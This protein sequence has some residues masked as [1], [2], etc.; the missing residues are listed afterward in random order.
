MYV[1][2]PWSDFEPQQYRF[3]DYAAYFRKVKRAL[4]TA[5]AA[6]ATDD[7]YPDPIEHC[8]I[9]RWREAC[10]KRRR[11]DDHLCLVAGISK[12]QINELKARD[13]ATVQGLAGM[14][15]PLEW[16][17]DRGSADSYIRIREQARIVVEARETGD[18][19][20]ELLPVETGFGLTRLPE[21]SE[22]DVFL[23]LEGDPF[24]GE[25]GLEYLFGYL[26][27]DAHGAL[28]YEGDWAFT[29]ADEKRAFEKF[30]DFVMARWALFPGLHV[31]HYAPYEPAALKRLM[32]RYATREEEIDRMLRAGLFVDLYQVVRHGLRASVESYSIKRLEPFYGF[33]RQTP[34]DRCKCRACQSPGESRARAMRRRLPRRPRQR[35]APTTR[36]TAVPPWPCATGSKRIGRSSSLTATD[37][38]RP[39]PGDGAP[40]EK[41]T[42][43][44]IKINALIER[45]TADVPAD[46][47]RAES[48]SS[49][50][51]G[52]WPISSIGTA[53]K[54][55]RCGGSISGWPISRPKI[56]STSAP[57]SPVSSLSG[58]PAAPPRR[59]SI[60]T[61][62]RRRRPRF[63]AAR[64]SA[65]SAAPNSA[66]SRR[67]RLRT[68]PSISRSGRTP[69]ASIRRPCSPTA[70]VGGQ[71][72]AEALVRIGDYVAEHG[73]RGDGPYQA[74]RDLLLRESPRVGGEPLHRAGETTVEAAV[75][76]CAI[77]RAAF[78]PIQGP[79]ARARPSPARR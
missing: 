54:K 45:L 18:R 57:D 39:Q 43:W 26:F 44:L 73:L 12:I 61:V 75:R 6:P 63:A 60:A 58:R 28:V 33:E 25:H 46:P 16:K 11:D 2:A 42:D 34:S 48:R 3:A 62:F 53:G 21:P 29:R 51:V 67:S 5:M 79:P 38:P 24:V 9:C 69:P 37:V 77:W 31:Y 7:T 49:R 56:C 59:R 50:P 55:R 1:V 72:M 78:C 71:V 23:D 4:L 17:P 65:I 35:C 76:L 13:I 47:G 20:F 15:L 27:K 40:N 70:Y 32:G 8:D 30:V 36:T 66:R 68:T 19:K 10:D 52:S 74:A 22:G 14:P 64:N 41:I